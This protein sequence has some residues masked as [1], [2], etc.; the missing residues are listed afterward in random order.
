MKTCASFFAAIATLSSLAAQPVV[1]SVQNA[2]SPNA[3]LAPG[4]WAIIAGTQLAPSVG[5]AD[6]APPQPTLDGVSV[7]VA[8]SQALLSYVSATEIVALIPFEAAAGAGVPL[9]VNTP[10]GT[11]P[12]FDITLSASAPAIF[13]QNGQGTG[14]ALASN[15]NY[16]PL[17]SVGTEPILLFATGMGPMNPST[18]VQVFLG[19]LPCTISSAG[20]APG[21][22]DLYELKVIPPAN[23]LSN[24]VYLTVNGVQSNIATVPI[25]AGTNVANVTGSIDGLYPASGIY[26]QANGNRAV[27]GPIAISELLTAAVS[28]VGFDILPNA[29][30][31]TVTMVT[32]GATAILQIDPASDTWQAQIPLPCNAARVY[33]FSSY[34][35]AVYNLQTQQPFPGDRVPLYFLDPLVLNAL[36]YV[37][38]PTQPVSSSPNCA[39]V[40]GS[41]PLGQ[42]SHFS[43]GIGSDADY[44]AIYFGGFENIGLAPSG[45]QTEQLLLIVDHMVIDS[46]SISY[47]VY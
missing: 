4:T 18:V 27:A 26:A 24:R 32:P 3:G 40:F 2:A 21:M 34:N 5:A 25:P 23:P 30:P 33:D 35:L 38:L 1:T 28:T 17:A 15:T 8:K 43:V 37:P 11:S 47:P 22:P 46:K 42:P 16:Q 19:E 29:Q 44:G 7:T 6:I 12:A 39:T 10:T 36:M 45:T 14:P 20:L 13:T 9:V 31:F 41:S